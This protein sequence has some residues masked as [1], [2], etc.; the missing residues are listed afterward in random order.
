MGAGAS[1]I[2]MAAGL[3][4]APITELPWVQGMI[5]G[6]ALALLAAHLWLQRREGR[7]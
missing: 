5:A 1:L 4:L 6:G 3:L 7:A 2:G